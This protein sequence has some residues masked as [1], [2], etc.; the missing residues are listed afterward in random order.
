MATRNVFFY[1]LRPTRRM[2]VD[3]RLNVPGLIAA[4]DSLSDEQ[5]I[6]LAGDTAGD[7]YEF[8]L[9]TNRGQNPAITFVRCR[10][11]GLPMLAQLATLQPLMISDDSQLAELTHAVFFERHLIGAEYNHYGPRLTALASYLAEKVPQ[12]LPPNGRIRI[13]PLLNRDILDLLGKSKSIKSISLSMSPQ[14]LN[15]VN[16]TRHLDGRQALIDMSG[17][18]G[19]QKIG[20]QMQNRDGLNKER[21]VALVD[22]ALEQGPGQLSAAQALV[23]LEDGTTTPINLLRTRLGVEREMELIGPT[24]RSIAHESAHAQIVEAFYLLEEQIS[25]ASGLRIVGPEDDDC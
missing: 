18:Y 4:L 6:R 20:M 22:W 1:E 10:E 21:V 7:S 17:G 3:W 8:V 15:A 13:G 19:A 16:A 5:R 2:D 12:C 11:H 14:L 9:V 25:S 23:Q 24:A